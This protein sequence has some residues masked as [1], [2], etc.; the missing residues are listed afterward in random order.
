M[1]KTILVTAMFIGATAVL[2]GA[3]GA[4]GLEKLVD[5]PAVDTFGTGTTYQMYH[6]FFLMFLGLLP[7]VSVRT[8]KVVFYTVLLG[9]ILFSGSIYGL[10]TNSLTDFDFKK[11]GFLTPLGGSLLIFAWIYMGIRI[12]LD[13]KSIKI[14]SEATD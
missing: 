4:H 12:F 2:L 5:A 14:Q 8:K 10:A 11:I 6:A 7:S 3:F 13:Q 1:N 9:I